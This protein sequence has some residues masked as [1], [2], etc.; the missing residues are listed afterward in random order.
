M[1]HP[2]AVPRMTFPVQ[3]PHWV[4]SPIKTLPTSHHPPSTIQ[5]PQHNTQGRS[6]TGLPLSPLLLCVI[7]KRHT[8]PGQLQ[9]S[10][11]QGLVRGTWLCVRT[12]TPGRRMQPWARGQGMATKACHSTP[13]RIPRWRHLSKYTDFLVSSL[14][15][16]WCCL[17]LPGTILPLAA[18]TNS[19]LVKSPPLRSF[20]VLISWMTCHHSVTPNTEWW[21]VSQHHVLRMTST[22][23]SPFLLCEQL[24]G[25]SCSTSSSLNSW[26]GLSRSSTN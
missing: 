4:I 9:P 18:V 22:F 5:S 21:H 6:L 2:S 23:L 25:R 12:G 3:K 13:P 8:P 7:H 24:E 16:L 10:N 26:P 17:Y 14:L 11:W 20:P 15:P 1:H 19:L